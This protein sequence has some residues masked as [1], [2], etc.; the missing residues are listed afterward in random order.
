M[1]EFS[2]DLLTCSTNLTG[3]NTKTLTRYLDRVLVILLLF[4][5]RK[6]VEVRS[7]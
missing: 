4:R 1:R 5:L 2:W 6:N 7:C 3:T